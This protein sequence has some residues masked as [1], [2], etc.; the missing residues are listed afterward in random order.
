MREKKPPTPVGVGGVGGG[1]LLVAAQN[2]GGINLTIGVLHTSTLVADGVGRRL[3]FGRHGLHDETLTL[4][5]DNTVDDGSGG[6]FGV[7][8]FAHVRQFNRRHIGMSIP[9]IV[10]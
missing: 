5:V 9:K 1:W 2:H 7:A 6:D 3:V 10:S 8:S 4:P